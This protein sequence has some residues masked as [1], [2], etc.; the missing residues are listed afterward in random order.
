MALPVIVVLPIVPITG[1]S[2]AGD[3]EAAVETIPTDGPWLYK[4]EFLG[5]TCGHMVL[6]SRH[7]SRDGQELV[8]IVMKAWN[9][10]FFNRIYRVDARI[11]SW[12][13]P[14][15]LTSLAYESVITEKG[16]MEVARYTVDAEEK[17]ITAEEDGEV[18]TQAYDGGQVLDP[19]AFVFALR[20]AATRPGQDVSLR[21]FTSDG[22][23]A[24]TAGVGALEKRKTFQGRK[25]LMSVQP[26]PESG[27]MFSRK[28]EMAIWIEPGPQRTMHRLDFKL[29]FGRLV[30]DLVGPAAAGASRGDLHGK[31]KASE[32]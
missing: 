24:T 31:K 29:S 13:D 28:G 21:L 6:E 19:L 1:G 32:G 27:S 25:P 9:S 15:N 30:A 16:E 11:D 26:A 17:T 7:E 4:V 14:A 12:V 3:V 2:D 20:G 22:P 8:H 23:L 10:K 18:T 5:I